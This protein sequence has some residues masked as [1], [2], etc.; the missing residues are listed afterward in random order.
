MSTKFMELSVQSAQERVEVVYNQNFSNLFELL[1]DNLELGHREVRLLT[2]E[3][4]DG[5]TPLHLDLSQSRGWDEALL[6]DGISCFLIDFLDN[7]K[8]CCLVGVERLVRTAKMNTHGRSKKTVRSFDYVYTCHTS[9]ERS[10]VK[11]FIWPAT[12]QQNFF[13]VTRCAPFDLLE[14]NLAQLCKFWTDNARV[15]VLSAMDDDTYLTIRT[16][17]V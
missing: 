2:P 17:E 3:N 7:D 4:F 5:E 12:F 15:I 6:L 1:Y 9:E 11:N 8:D 10:L 13:V 14:I 16:S